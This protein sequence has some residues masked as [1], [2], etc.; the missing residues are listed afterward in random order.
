MRDISTKTFRNKENEQL[1][2][3]YPMYIGA[4]TNQTIVQDSKLS[5]SFKKGVFGGGTTETL[6]TPGKNSSFRRTG[7]EKLSQMR[8]LSPVLKESHREN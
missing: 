4:M 5:T 2:R 7:M 3:R 8:S 1:I 6:E